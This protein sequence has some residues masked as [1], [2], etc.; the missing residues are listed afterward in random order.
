M[1]ARIGRGANMIGVLSYN[2]LKVDQNK[3]QIL[4]TN[5][6]WET[7]DDK[8]T[9]AQLFRS[10][11]PY[12]MANLRTEKPVLHIS[13]NPD[14]KDK[15]SDEQ[16][17]EMADQYMRE[18][19]YAEQPYIVFK[20]TDIDRTH[21]HIVS[22]CVDRYGKKISDTYEKLRSMDICRA[23][24]QKYALVPATEKQVKKRQELFKPV[25]HQSGDLK[26]QIAAVVRYLPRYYQYQSLGAYNAL[27]SLF[28]ITAE[29]VK[30]EL[31]RQ[32]RQGLVYFAL[33]ANGEK[34]SNPF[35]ASL[36]GKQA[37]HA[38]LQKHY[39][40][41]KD[42]MARSTTRSALKN[43][44]EVALQL[45]GNEVD[46]KKNLTDQGINVVIRRN[47]EGR[48]YGIT[49]ID[50]E[51]RSVWNGSQ[52]GKELSANVFN[53]LWKDK[54]VQSIALGKDN[55]IVQLKTSDEHAGIVAQVHDLFHFLDNGESD[56]ATLITDIGSLLPDLHEEEY[57][58][59][60][61][62]KKKKKRKGRSGGQH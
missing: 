34:V 25:D 54:A 61:F 38:E 45:A 30:G 37:G 4:A 24:E 15:V 10:F 33:N 43:S 9:V 20:H 40:R 41:S 53:A 26:S 17:R 59:Q 49:F 28:N 51:S 58:E 23:L 46:L 6:I 44:I 32:P 19:G 39:S 22:T 56:L 36:F 5:R 55:T 7:P 1:I 35:K 57:P 52:L 50:H 47:A 31:H 27:L 60:S 48:I 14:P 16:F 11:A 29:E 3:G 21:I 42:E 62:A 12:L 18:M 2:Q 13:L 8:Y